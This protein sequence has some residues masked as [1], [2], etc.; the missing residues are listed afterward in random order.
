MYNLFHLAGGDVAC[1]HGIFIR[2][3]LKGRSMWKKSMLNVYEKKSY[4][5]LSGGDLPFD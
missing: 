2:G 3:R 1:R 5:R 4:K